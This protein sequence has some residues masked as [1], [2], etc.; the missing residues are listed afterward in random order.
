LNIWWSDYA[1][2]DWTAFVY[3]NKDKPSRPPSNVPHFAGIGFLREFDGRWDAYVHL[4]YVVALTG[5]LPLFRGLR[6]YRAHRLPCLGLCPS[7]GYDLRA[8]PERCPECGT[9][10]AR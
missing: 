8:T 6:W 4:A 3:W 10:P 1:V 9:I 2:K 7:C 5:L